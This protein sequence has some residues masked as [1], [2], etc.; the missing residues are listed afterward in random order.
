[1]TA[2][3]RTSVYTVHIVKPITGYLNYAG[4]AGEVGDVYDGYTTS[5]RCACGAGESFDVLMAVHADEPDDA[6]QG[7]TTWDRLQVSLTQQLNGIIIFMCSFMQCWA[8]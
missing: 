7:G 2:T 8:K 1:M 3:C 6:C 4:K 5:V